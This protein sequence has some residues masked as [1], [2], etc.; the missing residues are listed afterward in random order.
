MNISVPPTIANAAG[1]RLAQARLINKSYRYRGRVA[2]I[3]THKNTSETEIVAN[4]KEFTV[5]LI[6]TNVITHDIK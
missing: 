2:R 6:N 5:D 4:L 1:R 3:Q